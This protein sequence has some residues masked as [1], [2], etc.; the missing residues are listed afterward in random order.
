M[1]PPASPRDGS[2]GREPNPADLETTVT[3]DFTASL[4]RKRMGAGLILTDHADRVL[5]VE[6]TY[7]PYWEIPGGAVESD[8]SPRDATIR[9]I[10]EELGLAATPGRLLV[11]D[12]VP[13]VDGRTEGLMLL[14]DGGMLPAADVGTIRLP[15]EELRSWAW[16]DQQEARQ[17]LS[18]LLT[19]RLTAAL[20]ARADGGTAYLENGY[21][22][23]R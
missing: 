4:P 2:P 15:A 10:G 3:E 6:P 8:E 23:S 7:K 19:R 17:R 14:F 21:Q 13:P 22:P 5:L 18:G 11:V 9:E 1:T 12:W 20:G 16:C